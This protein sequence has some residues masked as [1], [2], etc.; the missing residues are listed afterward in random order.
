MTRLRKMMLEELEC[1]NYSEGTTRCYL[2]AVADF[3]RYFHRPP[4]QLRPEHIRQYQAY[5]F[6]VRKL[7]AS[8]VTQQLAALR[9][10][11]IKTL[12]KPWSVSETPYPKQV[13]R[14]PTVLSQ[15]EVAQL[16]NSAPTPF[17]RIL[18][19]TLYATGARCA[20]AARLQVHDIDSQR[21]IVHI[22][23]G[24]GRKDRDVMLSPVLLQA[25]REH[26]HRLKPKVWLFP[27]GRWHTAAQPICTKTLWHA[28]HYAAQRAGLHHPVHPHTLRHCFATHL[29]EAGAD[30]RTIQLLLGHRDLE[31][32]TLYLHLSSR[33]L[34]AT[35][36][37]LDALA[38]P[39]PDK[40]NQPP[41]DE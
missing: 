26:W 8:S 6:R 41:G 20:E 19:M 3:A 11:F 33:R 39:A 32:T 2:R 35:A 21:M 29:H 18:V 27:G 7:D 12:K 31:E 40:K 15:E 13:R 38:L 25:L 30:L 34:S 4:D 37:P 23:G 36:S 9:F 5:L 14:L 17:Y 16:I 24:K 10:F 1:R 22:R 28:C